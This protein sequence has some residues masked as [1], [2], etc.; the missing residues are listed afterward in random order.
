M[1]TISSRRALLA[2]AP[3]AGPALAVGE[4]DPIFAAI[5]HERAAYTVYLATSAAADIDD[6]V[7]PPSRDD[8]DFEEANK[9]RMARPEHKAWWARWLEADAAHNE[10]AQTLW[11]ARV[12]FLGTQ[13]TTIAGLLAYLDH[14]EGPISTGDAGEAFWDEEEKNVA[15][16][17]LAAAA[18]NLIARGQ[19]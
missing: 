2:G 14:I 1:K 5:E 12:A 9:R 11:S 19:A 6:P 7:P 10:S 16:P 18:R 4:P 3:A 13:P 8:P 17:T 15:F